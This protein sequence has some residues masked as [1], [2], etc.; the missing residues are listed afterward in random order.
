MNDGAETFLRALA[1]GVNGFM[2]TPGGRDIFR[3]LVAIPVVCAYRMV[4]V[5]LGGD[6][7]GLNL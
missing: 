2:V 7:K 1:G 3:E 6:S 4:L 5:M